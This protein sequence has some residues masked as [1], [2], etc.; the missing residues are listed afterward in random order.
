MGP[1]VMADPEVD[2]EHARHQTKCSRSVSAGRLRCD[3]HLRFDL[4]RPSLVAHTKMVDYQ[5]GSVI[6][7]SHDFDLHHTLGHKPTA[8]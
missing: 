5:W 1:I 8:P 2:M 3:L 7:E 4:D 6:P